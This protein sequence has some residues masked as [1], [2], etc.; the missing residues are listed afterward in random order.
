V[1]NQLSKMLES[2][3]VYLELTACMIS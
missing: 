2:D 3:I 1:K